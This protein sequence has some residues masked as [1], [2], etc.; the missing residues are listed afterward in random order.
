MIEPY[1]LAREY[2]K[3]NLLQ[4]KEFIDEI[5]RKI[6]PRY[7]IG[8]ME[9]FK[10]IVSPLRY[11]TFP[12]LGGSYENMKRLHEFIAL[13]GY[14]HTLC[15]FDYVLI[16]QAIEGVGK[17]SFALKIIECLEVLGKEFDMSK[18]MITKSW[19]YKD[20]EKRLNTAKNTIIYFDEG[21]KFFDLRRSMHPERID[22]LEY[23][24]TERWRQ[25]IYIIAASDLT[26]ID[27]YFRDRRARGIC[28]IM[29][30][31]L[32]AYLHSKNLFGV[33]TDRFYLER[34]E[35]E[36]D[37]MKNIDFERQCAKLLELPSCFG[38]G[39]FDEVVGERW[40]QYFQLKIEDDK[41]LLNNKKIVDFPFSGG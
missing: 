14:F 17:S 18:D 29:D 27:K 28:M 13:N 25:N 12:S 24:T 9:L 10:L 2:A 26:E 38:I 6:N 7:K 4:N 35:R 23:F 1:V 11:L 20:V 39:F 22:M 37:E 36:I 15:D 34:F 41:K 19:S 32:V 33:G 5:I 16:V 30:R 40:E 31:G 21:K 8:H 3:R